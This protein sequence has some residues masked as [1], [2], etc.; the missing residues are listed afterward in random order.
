VLLLTGWTDYAFSTDNVAA[1]QSNTVMQAPSLQVQDA[2]GAWRTVDANIGFPVGRP[3]TV[4]VDLKGKWLGPSRTVRLS[5]SMRIYWDQILVDTSG[6]RLPFKLTTL[7][8]ATADL[9]W[10]GFSAEESPD[11]REPFRAD[12]LTVSASAPWK[13]FPGRYTRE[14]DV[15]PLL[16]RTDDMFV[17]AQPGDEIAL[18]FEAAAMPPLAAGWRRT[19]LLYANGYSK[20]MNIRSA[21]PDSLGPL[22]FHAMTKYPYG[23]DEHYPRSA[24]YRDYLDRYNTRVVGRTMPT[25]DAAAVRA[26]RPVVAR[27]FRSAPR[28]NP[29]P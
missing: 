11:G 18:T 8:P 4:V 20:E 13:A 9:R 23:E 26:Q 24:A 16:T 6:G 5:T 25:I 10:R 21:T 22:P 28:R 15:R 3:Q 7:E 12:Y 14:G 27:T 19:F 1:S 29:S 2:S 17:V